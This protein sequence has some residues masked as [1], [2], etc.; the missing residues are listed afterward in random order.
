MIP[1][2]ICDLIANQVEREPERTALS[3]RGSTLSYRELWQQVSGVADYAADSEPEAILMGREIVSQW[4]R[5]EKTRIQ[6]RPVEAPYYDPDELHGVVPDDPK[7]Q[8][9][10][11]PPFR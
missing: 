7:I 8:F 11:Q 6:R 5:R 4:T 1:N 3:Y 2:L 10:S 9:A